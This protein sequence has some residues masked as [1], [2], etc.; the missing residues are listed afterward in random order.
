M[1]ADK[2]K[3]LLTLSGKKEI[4]LAEEYGISAQ[5]MHNKFSRG[6]FS[7]EDAIK[8]GGFCGAEL[9]YTLPDGHKI[10][11]NSED[12]RKKQ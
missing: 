4:E 8:I 7:M 10:A 11:F 1:V 2:I 6:S 5:G 12:I 3:G 9:S